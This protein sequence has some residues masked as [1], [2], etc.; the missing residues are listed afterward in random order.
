MNVLI[1]G[2]T[3]RVGR[4]TTL[5]ALHAGHTVTAFARTPSKL[6]L[7]DPHLR[8]ARGDILQPDTLDAAMPNQDAVI[9]VYG[10]PLNAGTI[11]REPT[12]FAVGTQNVL[13]AMRACGVGRLIL[14]SAAGVG[15]SK[16]HTPLWFDKLLQPLLLGRIYRDKLKAEAAVKESGLD[17]II[18]RPGWMTDGPPVGNLRVLTHLEG[19]RTGTLRRSD[20]ADFLVA[21]LDSDTY[22]RQTPAITR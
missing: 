17:W 13:A 7:D 16:G 22:L 5:A 1:L 11:L 8:K 18:V 15:D 3:G 20:I 6:D 12:M 14:M 2:A 21:Q 4:L 19:Q 10:A 9:A